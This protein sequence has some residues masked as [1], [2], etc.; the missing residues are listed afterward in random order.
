[1]VFAEIEDFTGKSEAV[2]FAK[3]LDKN[4]TIWTENNIV[5]ISGKVNFR[6]Q[7]PKILADEAREITDAELKRYEETAGTP[8]IFINISSAWDKQ[9]MTELKSLIE[10]LEKG[11]NQVILN[12]ESPA[13]IKAIKTPYSVNYSPI[14]RE[15]LEKMVPSENIRVE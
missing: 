12:I 3:V 2:V 6:D 9:K 8:K 13:G 1:M 11:T 14:L 4:P 5:I 10:S 7:T 15:T